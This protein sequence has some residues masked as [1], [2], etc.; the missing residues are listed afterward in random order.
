ASSVRLF[1]IGRRYLADGEHPTLVLVLAGEKS[2]RGWQN[3]KAEAFDAFD[4]KRLCL[5]LLEAAGAPLDNM[6]IMGESGDFYHPGQSATLRLGP[7]NVLASFGVI[8]PATLK[9][10]DIDVPVVAAGIHLD[11]I[12]AKKGAAGFARA[13]YAPPLL[14][15]VTRDFAFVVDNDVLAGDLVRLVKGADK[16]NIT[17]VRIFDTFAGRDVPE[18]R[19]S[20]G[21]EVTL[22]PRDKSFDDAELAAISTNIVAASRQVGANVRH[23]AVGA[24]V[25]RGAVVESK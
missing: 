9:A 24:L 25:G 3:G 1:E 20:I 15:A 11:A 7:K 19:K 13:A 14:Q 18:G 21:V 16:T 2:P 5:D 23:E 8:H 12:P 6:Q 22:Q 10:F 17:A 4:A